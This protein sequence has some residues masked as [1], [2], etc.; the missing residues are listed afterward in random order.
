[1][2]RAPYQDRWR[3]G[4]LVE[5]GRRECAGRFDAIAAEVGSA[6]TLVDVGG[7]DGYFAR[8]FAEAGVTATLIEPR[9]V[10]ELPA[11]VAHVQTRADASTPIPDCDVALALAVLHHMPDWADVLTN[12]RRASR[13]LIVEPAV[14]AEMDGEL[15]PTLVK[16]GDRIA[17]IFELLDDIGRTFATTPGPNGVSRPLIAVANRQTGTVE[18]GRQVASQHHVT[19]D[20]PLGY[21]PVPGTLN[22]R[23]GRQGASWVRRLPGGVEFDPYKLPG[24]YF[25]VRL[26]MPDGRTARGHVRTSGARATVEIVAPVNLREEYGLVN[27]DEL[28]FAPA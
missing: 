27:G 11:G 23:V 1:M 26:G 10:P 21:E 3:D 22:V 24:P 16:T 7:W 17:P 2:A 4:E 6:Y 19:E 20:W 13:T 28:E 12:L 25:P 9:N 15:S 14:P 5:K 18:D 8:R